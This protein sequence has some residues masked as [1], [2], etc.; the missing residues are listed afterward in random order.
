MRRASLRSLLAPSLPDRL[1]AC[2]PSLLCLLAIPVHIDSA[3]LRLCLAIVCTTLVLCQSCASGS[4]IVTFRSALLHLTH[5]YIFAPR[6]LT[7]G[8]HVL[9]LAIGP[10]KPLLAIMHHAYCIVHYCLPSCTPHCLPCAT[11]AFTSCTL[12]I[13]HHACPTSVDTVVTGLALWSRGISTP[14]FNRW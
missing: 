6:A 11:L 13:L 7:S 12:G 8:S 5:Q 2:L 3:V 9:L 4:A 10:A 1:H 14:F